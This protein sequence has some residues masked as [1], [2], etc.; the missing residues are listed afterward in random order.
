MD[1][2]SSV[3][4]P[5][6]RPVSFF[7]KPRLWLNISLFVLTVVSTFA[8]GIGWSANYRYAEALS[9][10][11]ELAGAVHPWRDPAVLG[12]SL[13]YAVVLIGILLAHEMGHYLT[14]RRNGVGATLPFFIPAPTLIGTMGAFIKITTPISRKRQLFDV[15]LAG[16]LMS[17][18][19]SVP[20]LAVG[21]ALSKAVPPAPA[22][23]GMIYF[24]EPLLSKIFSLIFFGKAG[25]DL[26]VIL[27][28]VAFAGWVGLLVTAMNLF[29]LGQ[30]DGGH[31]AYAVFGSKSRTI[32]RVFL[33]VFVIMGIF[34]WM[35]WLI[36]ALMIMA[37]GL[38][39]PRTWD[40]DTALGRKRIGL[41]VLAVIMFVLSF[42]P[43]P[44]KG[45]NIAG[46]IRQL[47]P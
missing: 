21:M 42:I 8:V 25:A 41:A 19:L 37:L 2:P 20:A 36:W 17:F 14:C 30:L 10:H 18:F 46:L 3:P 40:E 11:P 13:L 28:P 1:E 43:D 38:R 47:W 27:H 6:A 34:F 5:L 22:S 26:D 24:G 16:P 32:G 9:R 45:Y 44:V 23:D 39:H 33:V 31:I 4:G 29:P 7:A 12:L 35:G 15:G